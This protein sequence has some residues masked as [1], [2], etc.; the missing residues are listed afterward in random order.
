[1]LSS[2][3]HRSDETFQDRE[4]LNTVGGN[5]SYPRSAE[6]WLDSRCSPRTDENDL[7]AE[8]SDSSDIARE[9]DF[10]EFDE[11]DEDVTSEQEVAFN[12]STKNKAPTPV[13]NTEATLMRAKRERI[14]NVVT[15]I[16]DKPNK[17]I[18]ENTFDSFVAENRLVSNL[19][20][21]KRKM[22]EQI[23]QLQQQLESLQKEQKE[24]DLE[25]RS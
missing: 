15:S 13:K 21:K 25:V 16:K 22:G 19:Q 1:M 3:R 20:L 18:E 9:K 24:C 5:G 2:R 7:I 17:L 6:A 23:R 12:Y 4:R 14:E 11:A 10:N 8:Q